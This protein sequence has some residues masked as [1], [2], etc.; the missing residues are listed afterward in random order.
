MVVRDEQGRPL[1][2][3]RRIGAGGQAEVWASEGRVAIKLM[4]ARTVRSAQR[5]RS[6][7][8]VIRRLDLD[9]VPIS[10]P[11]AML[12]APHVGYS[13]ELL[14]DMVAIQT[15]AS[16]PGNRDLLDWYAGTGGLRRRLRLLSRAADAFAALHAK[17]VV[18]ADPSPA[19]V[20]VSDTPRHEEVRLVD[21]DFVQ[22]ESVVPDTIATPGYAAPELLDGRSGVTGATDAYAFAVIAFEVLTLAHPFLGDAVQEGD[23][24]LL[25][26][27]YT[28]KLPWI[29][30]PDD[31]S[32]R[33]RYGLP[34][35]RVLASKLRE[36]AS[37][38]F[39]DGLEDAKARPTA[40]EWRTALR[41]AADL[42]LACAGCPQSNDVRLQVCPWCGLRA[43]DPLVA[44]VEFVRSGMPKA[45]PVGQMLA[46]PPG[47]WLPITGRTSRMDAVEYDTA[48]VAWLYWE[49]EHRLV[50]RNPGPMPLW[51]TPAPD[52]G[53]LLVVEPSDELAV[54]ADRA[55]PRWIVRFGPPG[56]PHR[57]LRFARV[58]GTEARP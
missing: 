31:P 15:L 35:E 54:P 29:D 33:T 41:S 34:R 52:H 36:L 5:L 45:A 39:Q 53:E 32:N 13:M 56:S 24:D 7:I 23:P 4:H 8:G 58:R 3:L 17:G 10:R 48:P 57:M 1:P 18:Y 21:V 11:L 12:A 40:G 20:M 25:E 46:V 14:D 55:A 37:R 50:V 51:L 38:T 44:V 47:E 30:H 9:G 22:S 28:G 6:R 2:L 42:T 43:P 49:A 16:A 26:H 19:N 27:A